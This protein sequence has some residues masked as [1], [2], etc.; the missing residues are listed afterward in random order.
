MPAWAADPFRITNPHGIGTASESAFK[1]LFYAGDYGRAQRLVNQAI[2]AEPKE[3]MNYAMAAALSYLNN[4]F[5]GLAQQAQLTQ[6]TAAALKAT[7]PLRGHLY[8]AVGVFMEGA[9]V[10]QTQGLARG[11]PTA[12]RM[13]QQ[14]FSELQAAEKVN[15][16][17][18]EL[19]LLKGFMDLL[20]AVNLP[21]ANPDQAIARLQNGY[22]AYLSHRGIAIGLRD[23]KR[24]DQALT[25][26]N[27]A[28]L[29]APK[30]P[31]LLYL[32]AQILALKG[33]TKLSVAVYAETLSYAQQLPKPVVWQIRYE[34]CL[35]E[36]LEG[37]LCA[38]R[39][40]SN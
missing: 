27:K 20:L 38:Q 30:N 26:V 40:G 31:D 12:L 11:T 22:P 32:K 7:D 4:D 18:P 37:N 33:D 2:A 9:H 15:P 10:L 36:G 6:Q 29:E 8:S 3:P 25:E 5:E 19:S 17:D 13:L 39:A 35:T 23:L 28:L 1:A 16:T 21:F 14:V 34:K 24:Y